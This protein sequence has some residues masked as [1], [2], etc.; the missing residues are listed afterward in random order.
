MVARTLQ[1]YNTIINF[2]ESSLEAGNH[3]RLICVRSA[4]TDIFCSSPRGVGTARACVFVVGA[5]RWHCLQELV[6]GHFNSC[7]LRTFHGCTY[8][9]GPEV[10]TV[11]RGGHTPYG[12]KVLVRA[13]GVR[14]PFA[15]CQCRSC[16]SI[17][18]H[19]RL[20]PVDSE[21]A[22]LPANRPF[23]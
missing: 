15:H 23:A 18:K 10:S 14:G 13:R 20:V 6:Y 4:T 21:T 9:V 2:T 19:C 5:C 7:I 3:R 22:M 16:C 8:A 1:Y 12:L 11:R 17:L